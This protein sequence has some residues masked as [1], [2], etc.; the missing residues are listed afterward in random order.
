[1]NSG[2]R[3]QGDVATVDASSAGPLCVDLDGTLVKS[4]TLVG[5]VGVLARQ[6]P[7]MVLKFPAWI[8]EGKAS[9]KRKVS[10]LAAL[11][12]VYLPYNQELLEYLRQQHAA[13]REIYL[14]TGA[15]TLLGER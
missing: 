3:L 1:M 14:A 12:V 4:D 11:D 10:S 5:T 7:R 15:D 8:A 9:F 13:G 6:N 2:D